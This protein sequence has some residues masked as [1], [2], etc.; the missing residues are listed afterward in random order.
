MVVRSVHPGGVL[1]ATRRWRLTVDDFATPAD[2][3][4]S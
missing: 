4:S 1:V 3:R 2:I